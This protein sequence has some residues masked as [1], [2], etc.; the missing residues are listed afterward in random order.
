MRNEM[1]KWDEKD[2]QSEIDVTQ[3]PSHPGLRI[4]IREYDVNFLCDDN[5]EIKS[6]ALKIAPENLKLT[7]PDIQKDI[8][9]AAASETI[10]V[11][12]NDI[13]DILAIEEQLETY[14]IDTR[15]DKDFRGLRG[16]GD[17]ANKL[18]LTKKSEVYPLLYKLVALALILAVA[19]VTVERVFF[20]M[21]YVKNRLGKSNWR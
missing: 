5:E 14:I 7:S 3:L 21:Y 15:S 9:S 18:V 13:V 11:M 4:P 8:V 12:I 1:D 19:T 20:A 17:I 2:V 16:L 6:P 10:N